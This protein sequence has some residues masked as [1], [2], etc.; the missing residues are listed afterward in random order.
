M[1]ISI[2]RARREE[3]YRGAAYLNSFSL[4]IASG[5]NVMHL[6]SLLIVSFDISES[7][8]ESAVDLIEVV[9]GEEEGE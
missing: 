2:L 8:D 6:S 7:A 1:Y 5:F 4:L 9:V 3:Q